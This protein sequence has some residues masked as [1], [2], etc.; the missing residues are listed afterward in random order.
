MNLH[1]AVDA[2]FGVLLSAIGWFLAML[3]GDFRSLERHL[4]ETYA[5][6]D[7]MARR[8]D[9]IMALLNRID[10]KLDRKVDK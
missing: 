7:E 4:P 8:F 9:E 1:I 2:I 10:E 3:H 5:R 6:R